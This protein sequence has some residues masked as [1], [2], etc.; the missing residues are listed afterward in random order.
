MTEIE[1]LGIRAG[2]YLGSAALLIESSDYESAV[3]RAYYAM[4]F[5]VQAALLQE[6][7]SA[8]SSPRQARSRGVENHCVTDAL[9]GAVL[10]R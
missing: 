8:R 2:K 5:M 1:S 3:S 4:Y 6:G 7:L 9:P 10:C